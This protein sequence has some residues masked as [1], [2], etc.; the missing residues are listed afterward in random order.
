MVHGI[1]KFANHSA[2]QNT[3]ECSLL[4]TLEQ[5]QRVQIKSTNSLKSYFSCCVSFHFLVHWFFLLEF[6][7]EKLVDTTEQFLDQGGEVHTIPL[8][9]SG[10]IIKS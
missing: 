5:G 1:K 7:T 6:Q 4:L 3:S 8:I 9:I 10:Q 2:D